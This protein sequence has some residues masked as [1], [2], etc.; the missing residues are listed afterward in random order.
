MGI[1][2][3][4]DVTMIER[5][6]FITAMKVVAHTLLRQKTGIKKTLI[7]HI[8]RNIKENFINTG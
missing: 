2:I 7:A 6:P 8:N 1:G 4:K 3:T 5:T